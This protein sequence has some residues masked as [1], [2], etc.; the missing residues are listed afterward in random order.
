MWWT[1]FAILDL[2]IGLV[3]LDAMKPSLLPEKLGRLRVARK[4]ILGLM[5]ICGVVLILQIALRYGW[6]R[7]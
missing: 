7:L 2:Y 3:V 4:V 1:A 6:L 5:A